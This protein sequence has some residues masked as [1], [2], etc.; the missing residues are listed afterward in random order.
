VLSHITS[1]QSTS[2]AI[3]TLDCLTTFAYVSD[4]NHYVRPKILYSG[5]IRIRNSRHPVVEK[6][7]EDKQFV[8]NDVTLDNISQQLLL[9]TGP[10]M[11]GK[12]VFI[13]Q[14]VLIVLMNQMGCF[15][16]AQ[17]AHLSLVDRIFVRSGASDVITSGMSTFMVEMVETAHILQ[18]ATK[19]HLL[20]WMRLVAVPV[21]MMVVLS[22]G[23]LQ[24]TS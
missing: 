1:I 4:K 16:P 15:V 17:S 11:A 22:H 6:L 24:N 5:E 2:I 7:L 8:P 3:A 14:V 12:S 13:R 20:L 21:H 23:Q 19:T 18:N 10:N 9:I